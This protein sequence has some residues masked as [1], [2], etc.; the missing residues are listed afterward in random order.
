MKRKPTKWEKIFVNEETNKGLTSKIYQHLMK[1]Y[2]KKTNNPNKKWSEDL[3]KHF[4]KEDR[5]M[6][7]KAHEKMLNITKY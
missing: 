3:N 5:H 1:L 4:S 6:A 7:Q 2:T